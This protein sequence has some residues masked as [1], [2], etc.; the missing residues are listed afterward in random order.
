MRKFAIIGALATLAALSGCSTSQTV[1]NG[2]PGTHFPMTKACFTTHGG[3]SADMDSRIEHD[4]QA[5][6][7]VVMTAP[8]CDR[9]TTGVDMTVAYDDHWWWDVVMYM[10]SVDVQFYAAPSGQLIV[11]GHW[12][13]SPMHQF[14]STD[15]VMSGLVDDMFAHASGGAIR[16][17]AANAD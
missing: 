15:G 6:G 12:N 1:L 14:P 8:G 11:N 5:H 3:N 4:L 7:V 13:N 2:S 16:T 9:N 17:T 10:K